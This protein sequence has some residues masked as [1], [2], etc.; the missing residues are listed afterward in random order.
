MRLR[1]RLSN[2]GM[3]CTHKP[4]GGKKRFLQHK[5]GKVDG[6]SRAKMGAWR[7]GLKRAIRWQKMKLRN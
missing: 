5:Q 3:S 4:E 2:G 1:L 7:L 6:V